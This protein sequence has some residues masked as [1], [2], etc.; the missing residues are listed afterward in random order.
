MQVCIYNLFLQHRCLENAYALRTTIT[1]ILYKTKLPFVLVFNKTDVEPHAF[2]LE[3]MHDFESFQQA[4]VEHGSQRG[5]GGYGDGEP[6]YM[7]SLINSM[8]LV[9]DEF[10]NHLTVGTSPRLVE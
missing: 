1:S 7:D 9:L 6:S 10:Y 2:A 4:L 5:Q 3:W 8:S